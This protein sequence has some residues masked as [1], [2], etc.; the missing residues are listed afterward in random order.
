M[1]Q[2][3][4]SWI[5]NRRLPKVVPTLRGVGPEKL[6]S[7]WLPFVLIN[8]GCLLRVGFQV[9]TDW[10]PTFFKLVGVSGM[11]EWTGLA[12]WASHLAAVMLG[13]GRYGGSEVSWGSAPQRLGPDHRVAAVLHWRPELE[14]VFVERGFD[15]IRNPVLRRTLAR[16][17]SLA[18][19]CRMKGVDLDGFLA[20]LNDRRSHRAYDPSTSGRICDEAPATE[21]AMGV[22]LEGQPMP[23]SSPVL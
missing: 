4:K 5:G 14:P 1:A 9:G 7:L 13:I 10:H 19:V 11:L 12:I 22:T 23:P 2:R 16:Q 8:F 6:P 18:Q 3:V 21:R 15:L 20:A 17:V